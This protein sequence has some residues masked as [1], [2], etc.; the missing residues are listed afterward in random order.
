MTLG[1]RADLTEAFDQS[2]LAIEVDVVDLSNVS[3]TF[4]NRI[5]AE[6]VE[7]DRAAAPRCQNEVNA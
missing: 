1:L 6:W 3:E 4:R 5:M 2:D 7:F